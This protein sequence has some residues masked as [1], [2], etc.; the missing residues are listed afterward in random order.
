V[1]AH[2]YTVVEGRKVFLIET[3][4]RIKINLIEVDRWKLSPLVMKFAQ[5]MEKG[6]E[7]PP[8]IVYLSVTGKYV[9]H[10][11]RHRISAARLLGKK[12]IL[13]KFSVPQEATNGKSAA[14]YGH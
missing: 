12:D 13:A 6:D 9:L 3:L 14:I 1:K 7:F 5:D 8:V 10:D 4:K 2:K 11:G